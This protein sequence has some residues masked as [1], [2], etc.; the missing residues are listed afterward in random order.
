MTQRKGHGYL[1]RHEVSEHLIRNLEEHERTRE[2]LVARVRQ[3]TDDPTEP[4][5][6]PAIQDARDLRVLGDD[7]CFFL[8]VHSLE[9]LTEREARKIYVADFAE[10]FAELHEAYDVDPDVGWEPGTE[11]PDVVELWSEF[12]QVGDRI[13]RSLAHK[14]AELEIASLHE[15]DR[16]RFDAKREAGR[17]AVLGSRSDPEELDG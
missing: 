3:I 4:S 13:F 14:H 15:T 9:A 10:R 12:E 1:A 17:L 8:I 7:V 5:L 6:L 11:P 2:R 16:T